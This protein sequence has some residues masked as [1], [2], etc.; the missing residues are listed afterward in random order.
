MKPSL[1]G[2]T[3]GG[4]CAEPRTPW[5]STA[6]L[7]LGQRSGSMS[8]TWTMLPLS[9]PQR[10]FCHLS[11]CHGSQNAAMKSV[12]I[13]DEITSWRRGALSSFQAGQIWHLFLFAKIYLL[14]SFCLCLSFLCN[15]SSGVSEQQ[16][17]V[18][19][20]TEDALYW[21]SPEPSSPCCSSPQDAPCS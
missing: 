8:E 5:K 16:D 7:V 13:P 21:S 2:G 6:L 11:N 17:E 20:G 12:A 14:S 3:G 19:F 15:I 1:V 4:L 9:L 10:D 18:P